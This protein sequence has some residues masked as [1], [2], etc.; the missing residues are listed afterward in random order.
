M[1]HQSVGLI[2]NG[3]EGA[4]MTTILVSLRPNVTH[5]IGIPRAIH[6]RFPMG[7][8]MGEPGKP[9][10]QRRILL[11]ALEVMEQ[12]SEPDQIVE[13]PYRWRRMGL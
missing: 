6:I 10:Q 13:L 8:P 2:A 12:L 9:A 7:N 1:C 5:G 11:S 3:I 4:G